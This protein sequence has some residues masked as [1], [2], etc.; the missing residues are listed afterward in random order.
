MILAGG[1]GDRL[2]VL[3]TERA[4]AAVPFGGSYR[5][6]DFPL[7]NC[8]NSD[9]FDVGVLT[10]Y[11]PR[12]LIE[13]IGVGRPWDLDRKRGGVEL[14]QPYLSRSVGGWYRGTGDALYQNL[15]IIAR[16]KVPNLLVLSGDHAYLMD[17]NPLFHYH[18]DRGADI[19]LVVTKVKSEDAARFGIVQVDEDNWITDFEEKP[20][21][22]KGD[23]A[24]MGIYLFRTEF[25]VEKL[26]KNFLEDKH[27]LVRNVVMESINQV[28]MQAFFYSGSWWDAGTIKAYWEANM[29]LLEPLPA[30]N[31]YDPGWMVF[32]NRSHYPPAQMSEGTNITSSIVGEGAIIEGEVKHSVIFPGVKL[33]KGARVVDSIIFDHTEIREGA[34]VNFSILDKN[35]EVGE[36]AQIGVGDD[37]T[38]NQKRPE[39][40][41]WGIN[42]I[43]KRSHIPDNFVIE[44][45]CLVGIGIPREQ[46]A[47]V[48]HLKSGET[49]L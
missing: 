30:F 11:Q 34:L 48:S 2:S 4:K 15:N 5:L 21:N 49:I 41:N 44:R 7:S 12:S 37:F 36:K 38:A 13:H 47:A 33:K 19:T 23:I 3:S 29:N 45:N 42:L 17:Y 27:D 28:K 9:I 46:F 14:L 10:Q 22:P 35:V 20:A 18:I 43:G 31:L 32:T 16:K 39:L 26:V 24:F 40:L 8:V 25:L 1:K 6:I